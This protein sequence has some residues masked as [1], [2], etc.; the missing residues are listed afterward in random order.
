M[1]NIDQACR[2]LLAVVFLLS[3]FSINCLS[4]KPI[5]SLKEQGTAK[6]F[7]VDGKPF[8]ALCGELTNNAATSID[9]MKPIWPALTESNLNS[10]IAGISWA[11]VEPE[12]GKFN[13]DIIGAVI[14]DARKNN[15][16]LIFI[17][18]ASWK[19]GLSSYVPD[20]VKKDYERFPRVKIND[21]E[22][23]ELIT[24]LSE[25]NRN[26]DA[27][28]FAALM[29]YIKEVDSSQ[30]TVIMMQVENEVGVLRDSRDRSAMANKAY[31]GP[32]PQKLMSYIE[33]NKNKLVP[34][35]KEAWKANGSKLSGTWE[36]V[37]G[38]GKSKGLVMPVRNLVP[39]M[40]Q[41]EQDEALV[42]YPFYSDEVFMA[43]Y[44]ATYIN[45]VVEAGK[46]EYPI[47]MFVNVWLK[48]REHSWPG[49]YPSGGCL[50][51][52]FDIY[53][54]GG[55]SIDI[56][57]PDLYRPDFAYMA[58]Q[59]TRSGNPLFIPETGSGATGAA[60]AIYAV[61]QHDALGFS[62]FGIER[63]IVAGDEL[64]QSYK[65]I[66]QLM[67]L[68]G[69][70]QGLN[71]MGAVLLTKDNPSGNIEFGEQI[72]HADLRFDPNN[73]NSKSAELG[74]TI[75]IMTS[76]GEFYIGGTG[77]SITF[78]QKNTEFKTGLATVEEGTFVEGKWIPGRRLAGD[79]TA[80]G[81]NLRLGNGYNILRVTLYSY[82]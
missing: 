2:T 18:F 35:L 82:K 15:L 77:M 62:P 3:F 29:K 17:W 34:E 41:K 66:S 59:F 69:E 63:R 10:V 12:E 58:E 36:E 73:L 22:S 24:P 80:Q 44:Y 32:V 1:K 52:V 30:R 51:Q 4:Q 5:P 23:I 19:N 72:F 21:T 27:R 60:Y 31:Y 14:N 28:A 70:H 38:P 16:K 53:H 13:F 61:G 54:A 49:T 39:P 25:E 67:P 71:S 56:L 74:A 57:C 37:F 78:S 9:Y 46:A 76:P 81:N 75:F 20:W 50:P 43:W 68:I 26:A 8:I 6:Q 7:I 48:Q 79:D 11:M 64:S 40:T 45:Y 33:K 65:M 42:T 55:P 47:P